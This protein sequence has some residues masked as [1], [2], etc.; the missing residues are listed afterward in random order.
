LHYQVHV[1][2]N[3]SAMH[4]NLTLNATTTH[5]VLTN[6]TSLEDYS[7][8]ASAFTKAGLGPFSAPST[9]RPDPSLVPAATDHIVVADNMV[10]EP[11]F[12]ALLSSV[13]FVLALVFI[14]IVLYRKQWAHA[15]AKG[16]LATANHY[17]DMTRLNGDCGNASTGSVWIHGNSWNSCK[18]KS[19]NNSVAEQALYAEVSDVH[20]AYDATKC[21]PAPYATT[22]I[23]MQ[24]ARIRTLVSDSA[25]SA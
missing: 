19:N 6:L 12:V 9:F 3:G 17:E 13:V 24:G 11:W 2:G 22:T 1:K 8:R 4:S 23:A 16:H 5:F 14:G 18:S 20:N 25:H 10:T 21:D 15:H 7:V